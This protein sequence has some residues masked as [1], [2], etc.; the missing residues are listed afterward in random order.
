[1]PRYDCVDHIHSGTRS[2]QIQTVAPRYPCAAEEPGANQAVVPHIGWANAV[3]DATATLDFT[4]NGEDHSFT[5]I[6]YHDK[7]WGDGTFDANVKFWYWGHARLG[8]YSIVWFDLTTPSGLVSQSGY[9]TDRQGGSFTLINCAPGSSKVRPWGAN[10]EYPPLPT[11]G[12]PTG[13]LVTFE[14]SRGQFVANVT[15]GPKSREQGTFQSYAGAITG[16]FVG[17]QIYTGRAFFDTI[18]IA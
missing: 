16:G 11:T 10:S 3:P 4:I 12:T 8:P 18:H 7:N 17:Q 13:L 15:T 1:M 2:D 5:G 9:I 6:G 14:T